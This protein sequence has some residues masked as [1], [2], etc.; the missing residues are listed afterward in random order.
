MN[1]QVAADHCVQYITDSLLNIEV[2]QSCLDT[3]YFG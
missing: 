1:Q 3:V 2:A